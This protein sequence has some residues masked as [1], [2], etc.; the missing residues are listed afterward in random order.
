MWPP[1][2]RAFN[3]EE[4]PV[5]RPEEGQCGWRVVSGRKQRVEK[6]GLVVRDPDHAQ[7]SRPG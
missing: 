1:G 7:P 5:H 2:M 3:T 4:E 6:S